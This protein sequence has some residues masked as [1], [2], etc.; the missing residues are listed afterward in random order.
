MSQLA[1]AL[2]WT[3][4]HSLWVGTSAAL[5]LAALL[6]LL[7]SRRARWRYGASVGALLCIQVVAVWTMSRE[8]QLDA[9][10]LQPWIAASAEDSSLAWLSLAAVVDWA[11]AWCASLAA[12]LLPLERWIAGGWL[13]LAAF[14][15][16]RILGGFALIELGATGRLERADP[17]M[18]ARLARLAR[19]IGLKRRAH[20]YWSP[21]AEVPMV[22]GGSR[23]RVVIPK[24]LEAAAVRGELDLVLLHELAHV[25]RGDAW[26]RTGE[27]LIH[28]LFLLNPAVTWIVSRIA[29][30]REHC[31]DDLALAAGADRLG[32]LRALATLETSRRACTE[33]RTRLARGASVSVS[34][35]TDGSLLERVRR[36]TLPARPAPRR[37]LAAA[38]SALFLGLV[39]LAIGALPTHAAVPR[40]SVAFEVR[41]RPAEGEHAPRATQRIER[42]F[43]LKGDPDDVEALP[44]NFFFEDGAGRGVL[45]VR[46]FS[47]DEDD[48]GVPRVLQIRAINATR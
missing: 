23:P 8:L 29:R 15:F 39:G 28:A 46:R 1:H 22:V 34:R 14:A 24:R 43:V 44:A 33:H 6:L 2:T 26:A 11:D 19:R 17:R 3:L 12:R 9:G 10:E 5:C 37:Q 38:L 7:S 41:A 36:L 25:K 18:Q 31:C 47:G 27:A 42:V 13:L 30:E 48:D 40:A 4:A 20:L 35:W 32:Y 16:T 21:R 45:H